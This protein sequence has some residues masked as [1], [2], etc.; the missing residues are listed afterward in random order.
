ME[1]KKCCAN[2][3][4]LN[5]GKKTIAQNGTHYIYACNKYGID[6]IAIKDW[7]HSDSELENI[8]CED[9]KPKE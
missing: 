9:F 6:V 4:F 8:V 3:K 1:V 7:V 2:C 5:K